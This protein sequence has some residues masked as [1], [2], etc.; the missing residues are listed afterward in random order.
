M[1]IVDLRIS[2]A[3][4]ERL[5]V[6]AA[7]KVALDKIV[8]LPVG[9]LGLVGSAQYSWSGATW[10]AQVVDSGWVAVALLNGWT[11]YSATYGP[12]EYRITKDR[13][14][15]RGVI[16]PGTTASGTAIFTIGALSGLLGAKTRK[17]MVNAVNAVATL[18]VTT[19]GE[20]ALSGTTSSIFVSFDGAGMG[21]E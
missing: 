4:T 3:A 6:A 20:F 2:A 19:A 21:L 17:L 7:S 16:K 5:T 1:V 12:L 9:A 10:V 18:E 13:I 14:Q 11:T 8:H 15:F